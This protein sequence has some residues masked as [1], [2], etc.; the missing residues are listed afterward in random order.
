MYYI[1]YHLWCYY[2][3]AGGVVGDYP[4]GNNNV[5]DMADDEYEGDWA[6]HD[7]SDDDLLDDSFDTQSSG[8][9]CLILNV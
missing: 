5:L 7:L 3:L 8:V 4:N 9:C 6:T 1:L 2:S